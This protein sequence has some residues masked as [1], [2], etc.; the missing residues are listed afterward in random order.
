ME[1]I[2]Q[3]LPIVEIYLKCRELKHKQLV[4]SIPRLSALTCHKHHENTLRYVTS[5]ISVI[6]SA[7]LTG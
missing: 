6:W 3:V 5:V 2:H 4:A 1:K 7:I